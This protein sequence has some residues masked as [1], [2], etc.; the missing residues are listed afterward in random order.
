MNSILDG[1]LRAVSDWSGKF[2]GAFTI[3]ENGECAGRQSTKN[4]RIEQSD[5]IT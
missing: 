1:L 5:F 4:I 3:R 2:T